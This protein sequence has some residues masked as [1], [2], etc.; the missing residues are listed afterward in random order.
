MEARSERVV[1]LG[2]V[3]SPQRRKDAEISAEKRSAERN[4]NAELGWSG[5]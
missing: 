4:K 1:A 3:N 2:D 5:S